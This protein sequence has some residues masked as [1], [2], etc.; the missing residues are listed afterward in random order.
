MFIWKN[1]ALTKTLQ[2]CSVNI[3]LLLNIWTLYDTFIIGYQQ[4]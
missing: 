4:K 2:T 3:T 1:I